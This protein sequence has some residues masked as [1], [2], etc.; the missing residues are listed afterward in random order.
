M[1]Y[2]IKKI[3]FEQRVI[4]TIFEMLCTRVKYWARSNVVK[5]PFTA[6]KATIWRKNVKLNEIL[7]SF[8]FRN[9]SHG[10]VYVKTMYF[11]SDPPHSFFLFSHLGIISSAMHALRQERPRVWVYIAPHMTSGFPKVLYGQLTTF[12]V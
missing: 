5:A 2:I 7:K 11:L 1:D 8:F 3:P 12:E 6:K 10:G 9:K 4:L